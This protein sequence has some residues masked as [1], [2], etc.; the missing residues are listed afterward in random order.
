[1]SD[2]GGE[3]SFEPT[4][5][6]LQKAKGE[7]DIARSSELSGACSFAAGLA[8]LTVAIPIMGLSAR[9]ALFQIGAHP[10]QLTGALGTLGFVLFWALA[11]LACAA[12]AGTS[13]TF[14]Q[15]GGL[16]PV[17]VS[18]K[19]ER[20]SPV[21]GFKRLVSREAV[22]NAFRATAAVVC[23]VIA[24]LPAVAQLLSAAAGTHEAQSLAAL[25]RQSALRCA[26][27]I[28]ALGVVLGGVDFALV[29][30]RW[31]KKLRMSFDEVRRDQKEQEGDP[32]ARGRRRSMHREISRSSL[33]RIKDA[34]FVIVN[35]THIAVALEYRPPEIAVPRVLLK[36]ADEAA[37]RVREAAT[38]YKIP[39]IENIP[40][41]RELF[42]T[43][44][45]GD[46]IPK[47]TY[48]AVAEIVASLAKEGALL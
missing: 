35:P 2:Q 5:S 11:P 41:A 32:A 18:F 48:I 36:A 31:R 12:V 33:K 25:A 4:Q 22:F 13:L 47:E 16:R 6:R 9:G 42:A 44:K 40:L 26:F 38:E 8:G 20:L 27:V 46:V 45:P 23:I 30:A 10:M 3:K 15:S 7:G 34:S 14:F 1:M 39:V 19:F 17:A 21:E 28:A 29:F 43:T 24:L 37:L